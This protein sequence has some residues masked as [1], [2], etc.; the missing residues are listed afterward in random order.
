MQEHVDVEA[1]YVVAEHDV[2]VDLANL[3]QQEPEEGALRVH[4]VYLGAALRLG[5]EGLLEVERPD[6][7]L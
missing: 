5:G 2:G 3:G 7:V 4:F 6:L 1:G